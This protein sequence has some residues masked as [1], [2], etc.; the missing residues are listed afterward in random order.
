MRE[1]NKGE[2]RDYYSFRNEESSF[3]AEMDVL[4]VFYSACWSRMYCDEDNF[5]VRT[6][7][8][9]KKTSTEDIP[10]KE[11]LLGCP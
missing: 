10:S 5:L 6:E 8:K 4:F 1:L 3:I 11:E 7:R 2:C 9:V